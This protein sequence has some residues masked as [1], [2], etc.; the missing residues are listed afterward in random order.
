MTE[1]VDAAIEFA[2]DKFDHVMK[3]WNGFD[4]DQKKLMIG[5]AVACVCVIVVA[6]VCYGLGKARGKKLALMEEDF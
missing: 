2:K 1:F 4:D 3:I 6:S 5:C